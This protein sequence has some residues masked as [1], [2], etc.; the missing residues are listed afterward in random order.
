MECKK[1]IPYTNEEKSI[2]ID[3]IEKYKNKVECKIT[4]ATTN[5][6][7]RDAW[8]KITEEYNANPDVTKVSF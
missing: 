5:K 7:K 6:E 2:L 8:S 4:D 3:T 1:V